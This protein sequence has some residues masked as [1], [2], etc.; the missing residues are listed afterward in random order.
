VGLAVNVTTLF[1]GQVDT[2][3]QTL[4]LWIHLLKTL[5]ARQ[6]KCTVDFRFYSNDLFH[7]H[8][9]QAITCQVTID[10]LF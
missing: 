10:F 6:L 7:A 4:Q 5:L 2:C 8:A 1:A 9:D 3:A